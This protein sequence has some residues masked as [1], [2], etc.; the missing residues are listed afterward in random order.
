MSRRPVLKDAD[1]RRLREARAQPRGR[2]QPPITVIADLMGVAYSTAIRAM[3]R[4]C[5]TKVL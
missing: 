5:Y 4:K 2:R 1:V 3:K